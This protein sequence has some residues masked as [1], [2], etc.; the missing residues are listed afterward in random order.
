[1]PR[2]GPFEAHS[3]RYDQWFEKNRDI[4]HAE[5]DAIRNLMPSPDAKGL[6]VGVGSGNSPLPWASKSE[7][8]ESMASKAEKNTK[9]ACRVALVSGT[10]VLTT[11]CP[12]KFLISASGSFL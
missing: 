11:T 3:D 7:A 8:S 9:A 12:V 1:M 6:E 4:Y 5:L 10:P 2:I